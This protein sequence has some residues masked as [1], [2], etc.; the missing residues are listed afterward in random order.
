MSRKRRIQSS[1]R[2]IE[3]DWYTMSMDILKEWM[4]ILFIALAAFFL[5]YSVQVYQYHKTYTTTTTFTVSSKNYEYSV[6]NRLSTVQ[7]TANSFKQIMDS[8]ILRKKAAQQ[9]GL[10]Y[11]PCS[12]YVTQVDMTNL[13]TLS[14]TASD[15]KQAFDVMNA[16]LEAYPEVSEKIMGD[17]VLHVLEAATVPEKPDRPFY[18]LP[19]MGKAFV[20]AL[21]AAA[22]LFGAL[23]VLRDTV[24]REWEVEDKLDTV[25]LGTLY[26]EKKYRSLWGKFRQR[27]K[28]SS[29]L[30]LHPDTS[31]RYVESIRKI[32]QMV[33]NKMRQK[34]ARVLLVAS[35]RENEGKST[36]AANL[37]LALAEQGQKVLLMDCD[38]RKP[39]QYKIF[40]V[41][42]D[43]FCGLGEILET[44]SLPENFLY[45]PDNL[46]IWLLLNSKSLPESTDL[47]S[48]QQLARI[49]RLMR[50]K[51]DY[52]ILDSS[53]MT[54]AADTEE[55][56]DAADASLLVVR[57]HES[58]V[59]EI[60]DAIDI[61]NGQ[62]QK[63][64]GCVF[65]DVAGENSISHGYGY[66]YGGYGRYGSYRKKRYRESYYG[67]YYEGGKQSDEQG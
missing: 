58:L 5:A 31:F 6:Y 10:S 9:M 28:K 34:E 53:P 30:L 59:R 22:F 18:P 35:V 3:F 4:S 66:G 26:H 8:S 24:R 49:I 50:G 36:V 7:K 37:A 51:M 32:A 25:L 13:I 16:V 38:L 67:G 42:K 64:L 52:I 43:D 21:A 57:Q 46:A 27:K 14:V 19:L 65:N 44:G 54:V 2:T 61:L 40:G 55:L 33:H 48:G 12:L 56:V 63:V 45:H 11:L 62:S 23:S 17:V 20:L 1:G 15:P 39:A 29:I 47:I 41:N 60:N